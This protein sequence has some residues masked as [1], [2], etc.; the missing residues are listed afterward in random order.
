MTVK[1]KIS[2]KTVISALS[3][4]DEYHGANITQEQIAEYLEADLDEVKGYVRDLEAQRLYKRVK[5]NGETVV[6][7][8]E[9]RH[10]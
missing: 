7:G 10:V 8:W 3:A 2:A 5:R 6:K 4:L 9:R 1:A